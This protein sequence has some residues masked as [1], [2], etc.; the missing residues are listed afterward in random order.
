MRTSFVFPVR[1]FP[2]GR[3]DESGILRSVL[4]FALLALL[5]PWARADSA[6][7]ELPGP[8][9]TVDWLRKHRDQVNVLAVREDLARFTTAPEYSGEGRERVL[10][11]PGGHLP[12]ALLL[13][14]A[15]V[16]RQRRVNA[17]ELSWMLP[18]ATAMQSLLRE[19]GVLDS[20]PTVI[21]VDAM[22]G[23]DFDMAARVYWSMKVYGDDDVAILS[24]GLAAWIDAGGEVSLA[25][26]RSGAGTWSAGRKRTDLLARSADVARAAATGVQIIDARP[27]PFY[28]GLEQHPAARA[29]GRIAG[30]KSFPPETRVRRQG[31]GL[32][33][34]SSEQYAT[35]LDALGI[36]PARPAIVYC[37][38]GQLAS[39]AW[40]VLSE[41]MGNPDV[42]LY[43]G[44][45]LLWTR[46]G[47]PVVGLP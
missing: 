35:V 4:L 44:S 18:R 29:A 39:G 2:A 19:T 23:S 31:S 30:S 8:L 32:Q 28:L 43:D 15:R 41:L 27:L 3:T 36:D 40:F 26:A 1:R 12:G 38:T 17:R 16:R 45:I 46:Q 10:S 21:V 37:N 25:P 22:A 7:V 5:A 9:V 13:D 14:Y 34:L 11:Q 24:G 20:R 47:R 42:R 6:Q 33:H